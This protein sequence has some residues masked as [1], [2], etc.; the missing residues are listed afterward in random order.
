[1]SDKRINNM[2]YRRSRRLNIF[3]CNSQAK[4]AIT[5]NPFYRC[6]P[7]DAMRLPRLWVVCLVRLRAGR[8][9]LL[10]VLAAHKTGACPSQP[11]APT[12]AS[13]DRA[14]LQY[15]GTEHPG[16]HGFG[17]PPEDI[18]S[19][20]AF[21]LLSRFVFPLLLKKEMCKKVRNT[22]C[23]IDQRVRQALPGSCALG[24]QLKGCSV[25]LSDLL[26]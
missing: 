6:S 26:K 13:P 2:M 15:Y 22:W 1:M 16:H 3:Y 5:C 10:S 4:D 8:G 12:K 18:F 20:S 24:H 7:Q 21:S 17:A 19:V 25:T 11:C 23:L 9:F 14:V